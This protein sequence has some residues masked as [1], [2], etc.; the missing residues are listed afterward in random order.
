MGIG[1]E[2]TTA[3]QAAGVFVATLALG[4][5]FALQAGE[6]LAGP[7][8]HAPSR[9]PVPAVTRA[10]VDAEPPSPVDR[11][12]E[13]MPAGYDRPGAPAPSATTT[14]AGSPKPAD[15]SPAAVRTPVPTAPAVGAG[16]TADPAPTTAP[17]GAVEPTQ[18]TNGQGGGGPPESGGNRPTIAPVSDDGG[19]AAP[20]T[21]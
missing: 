15:R 14:P 20:Q 1:M 10:G 6:W 4:M 21:R 18:G 7:E 16:P 13:G 3:I 17:T 12:P 5:P 9:P 11:Q 2:R 8:D 19:A